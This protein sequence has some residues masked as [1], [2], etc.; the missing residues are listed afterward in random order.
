MNSGVHSS[1]YPNCHYQIIHAKF[2]LKIFNLSPY[3]RV[4]WHYQD[5]N[6]DLTQRSISQ[7]SWGRNISNKGVNEQNL[8]F[9]ETIPKIITNL[10]PHEIKIFNDL[11]PPWVNNKVK[12]MIQ[13]KKQNLAALFEK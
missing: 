13:A 2:N 3:K 8:I 6:N 11:E 12:T 9:K 1:L 10:I 7:F 5:A 4:V